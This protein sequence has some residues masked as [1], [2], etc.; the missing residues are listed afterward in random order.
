MAF[1]V[2]ASIHVNF[3][4]QSVERFANARV[5]VLFFPRPLS[6]QHFERRSPLVV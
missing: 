5:R 1:Y 3:L 6:I 2:S 4:F